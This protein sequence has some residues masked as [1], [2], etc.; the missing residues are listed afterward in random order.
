[1]PEF[2]PGLELSRIFYQEAVKP[3]VSV[4]LPGMPYSA[5]RIGPGSEVLGFDTEMSR[6]HDWGPR[7]TIFLPEENFRK[8]SRILDQTL[9]EKLPPSLHGYSTSWSLPQEDGSSALIVA[10]PGR[11]NH[12]VEITRLRDYL[13]DNLGFD[14]QKNI[15]PGDWLFLPQQPLLEMT[16]GAVFHDHLGLNALRKKL[17]WYPKDI[18]LYLLAAAWKRIGQEEHLMGRAGMVGDELGSKIIAARL[19]RDLMRLGFLIEKRYA[20]YAKWFGTAFRQLDCAMELEPVLEQV[21]SA[22]TWQSRDE[23]LAVGYELMVA[24]FNALKLTK[25]VPSKTTNFYNRPLRVIWGE[26]IAAAIIG[27][28]KDAE[29]KKIATRTLVGSVDQWSDNVDLLEDL[30]LVN[31][32]K[33]TICK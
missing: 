8:N 16:R 23:Y 14:P 18:W 30:E 6:D 13:M 33:P 21:L 3:I 1:M 26:K 2:I 24:R 17:A 9:R 4:A 28:I 22:K 10:A 27:R 5:A 7:L 11:V 31:K 29:V 25:P 12:R 20:P 15:S 19:V 32:I